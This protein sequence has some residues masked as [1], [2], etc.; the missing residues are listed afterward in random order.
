MAEQIYI[1]VITSS[2]RKLAKSWAEANRRAQMNKERRQRVEAEA[3][4]L[5]KPVEQA[6]PWPGAVPE[7][8]TKVEIAAF[9]EAQAVGVGNAWLWSA[10]QI[11][12]FRG[13]GSTALNTVGAP[14]VGIA[15][16][17]SHNKI[18]S[19]DGTAWIEWVDV[20]DA[21]N[22]IPDPSSTP[23]PKSPYWASPENWV[24]SRHE[25]TLRPQSWVFST[26]ITPDPSWPD[27]EVPLRY[28]RNNR[29]SFMSAD[30]K[31]VLPIGPQALLYVSVAR[32]TFGYQPCVATVYE[33]FDDPDNQRVVYEFS[34]DLSAKTVVQAKAFRVGNSTVREIALPAVFQD[35]L[36]DLLP[37]H[38]P[39]I[40]DVDYDF[41]HAGDFVQQYNGA[42]VS[43][44]V[45]VPRITWTTVPAVNPDNTWLTDHTYDAPRTAGIYN[46]PSEIPNLEIVQ[47]ASSASIYP[48]LI[49]G[50]TWEAD[51]DDPQAARVKQKSISVFP[52]NSGAFAGLSALV[53]PQ[54]P[55][56][57]LYTNGGDLY[58]NGALNSLSESRTARPETSPPALL[59]ADDE[60]NARESEWQNRL[61]TSYDWSDA[62]FCRQRLLALGFSLSDLTP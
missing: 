24:L 49:H 13:L 42:P 17:E 34:G 27:G 33:Y 41:N 57:F 59:Y 12:K 7:T 8:E 18:G 1:Q 40:V 26:P 54:Q 16:V 9:R 5:R 23:L 36:L 30:V 25:R 32:V 3:K 48:S 4:R 6:K 28:Q 21:S 51:G 15:A 62:R 35:T 37:T 22:V 44:S 19:V 56:D 43:G 47:F 31:I 14:P 10:F 45:T 58:F 46:N 61:Y 29:G 53:P 50:S 55:I 39:S 2:L 38:V 11:S 52:L 60:G 20:F